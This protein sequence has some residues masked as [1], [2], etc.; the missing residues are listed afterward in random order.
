VNPRW[1]L[2]ML[3]LLGGC[4]ERAEPGA[5][6][7]NPDQ[8]VSSGP[9]TT[10]PNPGPTILEVE[11][12]EGLVEVV[13]RI[14]DTAEPLDPKTIR[15]EFY[16]GVEECEGLDHVDVEETKDTVTITLHTGRVPEAEV[17]IEIALLKATTV[18]LESPLAGR[19]IVDGAAQS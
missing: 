2:A 19:E 11:P 12:R 4:A 1:L 9:V 3:L 13:P 15:V 8:P 16:G 10:V 5:G 7:P 17:C 6:P 18:E 14:F